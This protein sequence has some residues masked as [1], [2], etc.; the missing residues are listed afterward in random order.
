MN[1]FEKI[2]WWFFLIWAWVGILTLVLGKVRL[3]ATLAWAD[4]LFLF[5]AALN[6]F[7]ITAKTEGFRVTTISFLIIALGSGFIETCGAL[8]GWPFGAYSYTEHLGWRLGNILPLTI[9]LAWWTVIGIGHSFSRICFPSISR[10]STALFCGFWAV[11]F[12]LL[13]EPFAWKVKEY[14]IWKQ[15]YVPLNNYI[16]WF[17]TAFLLCLVCPWKNQPLLEERGRLAIIASLMGLT[18]WVGSLKAIF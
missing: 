17:V 1:R 10:F 11:L 13:L 16:A 9:P 15:G 3:P 6:V 4:G 5:L 7:L 12:D 14:W 18:F 2:I 8:T